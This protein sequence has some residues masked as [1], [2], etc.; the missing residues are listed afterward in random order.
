[1]PD[2][3][4]AP[5]PKLCINCQHYAY[6]QCMVNVTPQT[7]L[8]DGHIWHPD[9]TPCSYM[10]SRGRPCGPSGH[11]YVQ[12]TAQRPQIKLPWWRRFLLSGRVATDTGIC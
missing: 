1:M 5:T 7:D 6:G 2:T 4:P 10:R 8:V 11:H 3:T 12:A 9:S